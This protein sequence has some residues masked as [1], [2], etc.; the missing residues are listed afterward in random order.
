[1][2]ER[3]EAIYEIVNKIAGRINRDKNSYMK[4]IVRELSTILSC[5]LLIT[6]AEKTHAQNMNSPYSIYGIG[7]MDLKTYNRTSGMAGTGFALQSSAYILNK[8][9]ASIA[10]LERSFLVVNVATTGKSSTYQGDVINSSNNANSDFWI[11]NISVASKINKFWASNIGFGQFSNVNYKF[12]G[13][14]A[15]EGSTNVY[16][17][18]YEGNGGLNEFYWNNAFSLGKHFSVGVKSSLIAGSINQ[19]ETIYDPS[20]QTVIATKQ[21]DYF[22]NFRFQYGALYNTKLTKKW[23]LSVGGRYSGKTRLGAERSLTVTQDDEII[24]DDQFIKKDRFWLPNTYGAGIALTHNKKTTFALD[25]SYEDWSSLKIKGT[26]WRLINSHQLSGGIEFSKLVQAFNRPVERKF[27]QLGAFVNNSYLQ[28][29]SHPIKE[30]GFTAGMGGRLGNSLLYSLSGEFG[31]RGTRDANLIKESYF[32][33]T[34]TLSYRDFLFSK[35]RK[36]D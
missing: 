32:Q 23:D 8:N 26:G 7:D 33:F 18:A 14:Q 29:R 15:V 12:T 5:I 36:Y 34:F 11:K 2:R 20:L 10:G 21:Q 30:Y 19:T 25:Y 16:A 24:V 4:K 27:Y 13:S 1:M 22:N 31:V 35:G 6:V 3:V 28:V 9:P 17:T